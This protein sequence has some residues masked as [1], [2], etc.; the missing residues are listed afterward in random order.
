MLPFAKQKFLLK[1]KQV[2]QLPNSYYFQR[3]WAEAKKELQ[4]ER[5]NV[6]T[7]TLDREQTLRNAMEKVEEVAKKLTDAS[8]ACS[9]AEARATVAE[10]YYLFVS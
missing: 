3:D 9:A 5:D 1:L 2:L 10:V 6:R 4:E 8:H 7:L